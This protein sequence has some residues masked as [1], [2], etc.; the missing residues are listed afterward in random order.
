MRQVQTRSPLLR[1]R[2]FLSLLAALGFA[3]SVATAHGVYRNLF[4]ALYDRTP[5]VANSPAPAT[6]QETASLASF[7]AFES[8]QTRPLALTPSGNLLVAANTPDNRLEVYKITGAGLVRRASIPV[9]LEPIAVAARSNTEFWVVNLLSDSV[10]VVSYDDQAQTGRVKRTLLVGDEPRDIVFGGAA[11]NKAFITTA[12]RGQNAPDAQLTTPG[13]GRADVWV[14]DTLNLGDSLNG[15]PIAVLTL[16]TDAPR[17]LAVSSDGSRVYAAGFHTG[18]QTT[19][20]LRSLLP[21]GEILIPPMGPLTNHQGFPAPLVSSVLHFEGGH[22]LD[23]EGHVWDS[24]VKLSL[25]DHDVFTID[26][27]ASPPKVIDTGTYSG[28]GT[29]LFNMAVNPVSGAVYVSNTDANNKNRFEGPGTFYGSSIRGH[30]VE[31]RITVLENG[32]VKPR[33]L[34]KHIDY[35]APPEPIPNPTNAKSL[36][37]P[38]E[39]AVSSDGARLYVAALGSDKVGVYST[40]ELEDDSF[41]PSE[42]A[43]IRVSGGGPTGLVLDE[44]RN[45]LYVLTRFDDGIS[46]ISLPNKAEIAHIRMYDPEPARVTRGRRLLYDAALTSAK[47]DSACASCHVFGD[48]D[49]I[50][51]DLGNPDGD[52]LNNPGPYAVVGTEGQLEPVLLPG[53]LNVD[54]PINQINFHPM[55]GPMMTQSLR[56]MDNHGPMHWRGD[57]TGGNDGPT[58][59]PDRGTFDE[60]AAF[61]K[62]NGAFVDLMGRDKALSQEDMQAFAD[63]AL[64]LTYPPNPVRN[65]D[66]SLTPLQAAGQNDFFNFPLSDQTTHCVDCHES[67]RNGNAGRT[68]HPGFF[69]TDGV[70]AFAFQHQSFKVPHFRNLYQKVGRFGFAFSLTDV[71]RPNDDGTT[72]WEFMGDQVSGFGFAHDGSLD[73]VQRFTSNNGFNNHRLANKRE[74]AKELEAFLLA[75]DSNL[76]PIVGQQVTYTSANRSVAGPRADLL[77]QRATLKECDLVARATVA[78]KETGYLYQQGPTGWAFVP[79]SRLGASRTDAQLRSNAVASNT[80]LTFTCAPPGNGVRIALDR[81]LDGAYDNDE[82]IAGTNPADPDS[83]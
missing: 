20:A 56:G 32:V 66:N 67:N 24:M 2:F 18:N 38:L 22:W 64:E 31:S 23:A 49:S 69:G 17:A 63:F 16:F 29:T 81:D 10:S 51:W 9:G 3:P 27:D 75:F 33:H 72:G 59:Q 57:R 36:A 21:S 30:L 13:V 12:H 26:A 58:A 40:R 77:R 74:G 68:R 1:A 79:S 8:G 39:M 46:T 43:Q 14:Y 35:R 70:T 48:M 34:N 52:M 82:M 6:P 65:L 28:V 45:R 54:L 53:T 4:D 44:A 50:A 42:S 19:S 78:G 15:S 60:V 71:N 47:G 25:P 55:K 83:R 37:F 41:E 62:F 61:K 73:T 80:P 11:R 7:T 76:Y 5:V